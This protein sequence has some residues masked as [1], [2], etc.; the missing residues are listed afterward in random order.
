MSISLTPLPPP[1]PSIKSI[2]GDFVWQTRGVYFSILLGQTDH[3]PRLYIGQSRNLRVRIRQHTDFRYRRDN[4]SLHYH[5]L[6]KSRAN[7]YGILC[8]LP[9]PSMGNH[10]L[11]GMDEPELLL[12]VLE[13][14]MC[15]V[16]RCLPEGTLKEWLPEGTGRG[17]E[18]RGLNIQCPLGNGDGRRKWVDLRGAEDWIVR[19]WVEMKRVESEGEKVVEEKGAEEEGAE[20][21]G[22]GTKMSSVGPP[23]LMAFCV[24]MLVGVQ[25]S[26]VTR[27]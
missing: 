23:V 15:L 3:L 5:A 6:Q 17:G 14:W 25:L 12:N 16:F 20:N 2:A 19:E 24:G 13:M 9:S 1:P 22:V 8:V 27:R 10:A 4:P 7:A 18:V 21:Q 11:P 26:R